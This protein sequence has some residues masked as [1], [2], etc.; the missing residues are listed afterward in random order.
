MKKLEILNETASSIR[1][2]LGVEPVKYGIERV[3]DQASFLEMLNEATTPKEIYF[4]LA[5]AKD[6]ISRRI[7]YV[8]RALVFCALVHNAIGYY[9]IQSNKGLRVKL[10]KYYKKAFELS[11]AGSKE[12]FREEF[13]TSFYYCDEKRKVFIC[14]FVFELRYLY[15]MDGTPEID[16]TISIETNEALDTEYFDTRDERTKHPVI[17]DGEIMRGA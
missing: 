15:F 3:A 2:V 10:L 1:R 12:D 14:E 5:E 17:I 13:R 6:V 11:K 7:N 9:T 8:D 4:A 16:S